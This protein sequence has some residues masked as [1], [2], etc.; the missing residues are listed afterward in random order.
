MERARFFLI[1][2]PQDM[3]AVNEFCAELENRRRNWQ[4]DVSDYSTESQF[5][6]MITITWEE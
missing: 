3:T 6:I 4:Y 5:T 1:Q 2:K